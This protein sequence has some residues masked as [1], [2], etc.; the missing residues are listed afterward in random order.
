MTWVSLWQNR[1]SMTLL[2][3]TRLHCEGLDNQVRRSGGRRV[4]CLDAGTAS[5][6]E[7]SLAYQRDTLDDWRNI[8]ITL[9]CPQKGEQ[10]A[11][12]GVNAWLRQLATVPNKFC[13]KNQ[14]ASGPA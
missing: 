10:T 8:P 2:F 1:E 7:Q 4:A 12:A 11:Q 14:S 3:I 6:D 9:I 5:I 13:Q